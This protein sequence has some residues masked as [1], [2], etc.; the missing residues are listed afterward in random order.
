MIVIKKSWFWLAIV[1]VLISWAANTWYFESKQIDA[2]IFLNHYIEESIGNPTLLSLYYITNKSDHKEIQ[3]ITMD[4]LTVY[5]QQ[6]EGFFYMM[7]NDQLQQQNVHQEF[8]HHYIRKTTF[9]ISK[10]LMSPQYLKNGI[11]VTN[12]EAVF[13][14]SPP[15]T[16]PIGHI[17]L[18][19]PVSDS[20]ALQF[21]SNSSRTLGESQIVFT[22][23]EPLS[24][25]EIGMPFK[26]KEKG[27]YEI[28]FMKE[29]LST[30][31][32]SNKNSNE[33]QATKWPIE[34]ES[35]ER[36]TSTIQFNMKLKSVVSLQFMIKGETS[37]EKPFEIPFNAA[38]EPNLSQSDLNSYL[39]RSKE[40]R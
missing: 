2:P 14:E 8:T 11:D 18:L 3:L 35:N 9:E 37:S 10:D 23:T 38:E 39:N 12:I 20:G 28:E 30:N 34:L 19:P 13:S 26:Q 27:L 25:E 21:L 4:G 31:V 22:A 17:R 1:S 7:N 24:I 33:E 40:E 32:D 15:M 5:P 36:F 16:V 6:Q 29:P